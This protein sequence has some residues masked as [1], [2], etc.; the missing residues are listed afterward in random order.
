MIYSTDEQTPTTTNMR[1]SSRFVIGK[2]RNAMSP[3]DDRPGWLSNGHSHGPC[4]PSG[5]VIRGRFHD[6]G[7]LSTFSFRLAHWAVWSLC[8]VGIWR[9]LGPHNT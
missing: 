7:F 8:L 9:S 5:Y 2:S 1:S 4:N 6:T 3:F